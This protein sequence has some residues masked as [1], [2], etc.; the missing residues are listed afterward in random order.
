MMTSFHNNI[1]SNIKCTLQT[2]GISKIGENLKR[3]KT[4]QTIVM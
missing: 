2:A 3:S 1:N 4:P